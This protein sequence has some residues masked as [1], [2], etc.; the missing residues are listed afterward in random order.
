MLGQIRNE[1]KL[2]QV[3]VCDNGT[4]FT[5]RVMLM[6]SQAQAVK[7]Q[8][9]QPGKPTQNAFIE[10]FNGKFRHECLRQHWF[11]S[12]A[13]ARRI[14]ETWR[15]DYNHVRPHRSLGQR[16]PIEVLKEPLTSP[17][18]LPGDTL[19]RGGKVTRCDIRRTQQLT[20]NR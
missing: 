11:G 20:W 2:P 1:G 17:K 6:W 13:E 18:T 4:E 19:T 16:T 7:L 12:P 5:S 9:I 8:F 15:H 14:I 3:V 10:S